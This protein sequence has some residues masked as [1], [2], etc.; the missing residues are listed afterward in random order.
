MTTSSW[1]QAATGMLQV[2][3]FVNSQDYAKFTRIIFDT[4]PTGHT[5]RLLTVPDFVE[6]SLNKL[7]KLRKRLGSAGAAL[8]GLFGASEKQDAAVQQLEKLR[9]RPW[10]CVVLSTGLWLQWLAARPCR[11]LLLHA[12]RNCQNDP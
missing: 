10:L 8:R 12:D 2:V 3:E 1:C 11:A 4:A 6:A 9:V 7:I 5:L